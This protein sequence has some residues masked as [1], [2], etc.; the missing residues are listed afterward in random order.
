MA[1]VVVV[2]HAFILYHTDYLYTAHLTTPTC[3]THTHTNKQTQQAVSH[4]GASDKQYRFFKRMADAFVR[5]GLLDK[6]D[7]GNAYAYLP[8]AGLSVKDAVSVC[9]GSMMQLLA[10]VLCLLVEVQLKWRD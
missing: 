4:Y 8:G 7:R 9:W 3:H 5:V 2:A 1:V 6:S 10:G